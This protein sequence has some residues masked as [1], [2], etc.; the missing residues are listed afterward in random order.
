MTIYPLVGEILQ[1]VRGG[2]A[3]KQKDI[4]IPIAMP[5]AWL[6]SENRKDNGKTN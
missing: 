3:D 2:Q 4:A 1:S 6:K 5:L